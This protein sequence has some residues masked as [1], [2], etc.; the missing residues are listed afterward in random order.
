ME[1]LE[2]GFKVLG[3]LFIILLIGLLVGLVIYFIVKRLNYY[4]NFTREID[5]TNKPKISD[6]DLIDY[7]IIN[8]GVE[9]VNKHIERINAWKKET[10]LKY[11]NNERKIAKFK[12]R[13]E[14]N[15]CKAF[16]LIGVRTQTRYRQVN[17]VRH[18]YKVKVVSNR[19]SFNSR[20]IIDRINFLKEHDFSVT[21]NNFN[22]EDQR[23]A[24]TKELK[25]KIKIRDNY[26]C[27][28]CGKYMPDE[29]GLHID[30]IIPIVKG[31]K[32]IPSNLRVLCSKCN[33]K[34]GGR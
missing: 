2:G 24:L 15:C 34:K 17:Y 32:S 26:T 27:Q 31:G 29:V 30:H 21:Y 12:L 22:K 10:I 9:L 14:K 19:I 4:P 6:S 33:G 28:L 18:P 3:V 1:N 5:L 25:E 13:C 7:Y 23:K 20:F 11:G 16:T 8:F